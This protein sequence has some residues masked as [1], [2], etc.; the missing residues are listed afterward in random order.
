MKFYTLI[1]LLLGCFMPPV[2]AGP[3]NILAHWKFEPSDPSHD[4]SGNGHSLTL[5]GVDT[6][7]ISDPRFGGALLI[8]EN[9]EH[10]KGLRQGAAAA[11]PATLNPEGAFTID[12]WIRPAPELA[13]KDR[14]MLIDKKYFFNDQENPR[15]TQGY[16][17]SLRRVGKGGFQIDVELGFGTIA[18]STRS[19][20]IDLQFEEWQHLIFTYDGVSTCGFYFNGVKIDERKLTG[21][22]S[23][24]PSQFPVAIGDRSGSNYARFLGKIT[25]VKI[26]DGVAI[27]P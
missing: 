6:H 16:M 8:E 26:L 17:L 23:V 2:L 3:P 9:V 11:L 4:A 5:R 18:Q 1:A 22:G 19:A 10:G 13:D 15:S 21:G 24:A 12:L 14:V 27:T 25:E 7:F 20:L